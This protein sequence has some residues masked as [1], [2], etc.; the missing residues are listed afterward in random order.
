MIPLPKLKTIAAAAGA[1]VAIF[2]A[3]PA[4]AFVYAV[5]HLDIQNLSLKFFDPAPG[6]TTINSFSF[7]LTN[8]AT[9]NGLS[10]FQTASCNSS[11]SP[12][13]PVAASPGVQASVLNAPV[14]TAPGSIGQPAGEDNYSFAVNK[15]APNSFSRGDS[16][17]RTSEL[18]QAPKL[19]ST[20]QIAESLLNITG[21]AKANALIQSNTSLTTSV[22]FKGAGGIVDLNFDAD[23]DQSAEIGGGSTGVL[24]QSDLNTSFTLTNTTG[25]FVNFTPNGLGNLDCTSNIAGVVCSVI[26]DIGTDL[27]F[28]ASRSTAGITNNSFDP[29]LVLANF[30][31]HITGLGNDTYQL[32][33]NANTSTS[34]VAA[35]VP[36]PGTTGL[37]GAALAGLAFTTVR[38][39][40]KQS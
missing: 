25:G 37:V 29:G 28:N 30:G 13:V 40:R 33:F 20:E 34:I 21:Q 39:K 18:L 12:C 9:M 11:S 36:E 38:R 31:I 4:S 22:S 8:S 6:G 7:D 19:T 14:A 26:N 10:A 5:S 16:I 17:I 3:T 1:C 27:N 24:A 2:T 35:A 15:F 23:P 32:A